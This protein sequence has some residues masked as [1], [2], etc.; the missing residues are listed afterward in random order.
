MRFPPFEARKEVDHVG[1]TLEHRH[2]VVTTTVHPP[3]ACI[4]PHVRPTPVRSC[5]TS[6][7]ASVYLRN[8]TI[9]LFLLLSPTQHE[10][11]LVS[12]F[13]TYLRLTVRIP[14]GLLPKALPSSLSRRLAGE[15]HRLSCRHAEHL[16]SQG[17]MH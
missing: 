3:A 1:A 4:R 17:K 13:G 12:F 16:R 6:L 9:E 11:V 2:S 15:K 14:Q 8:D 7:V 10:A 5:L